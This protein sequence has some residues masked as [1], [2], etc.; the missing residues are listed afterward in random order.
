[1][2]KPKRRY[3]IDWLRVLLIF[4]VF[5]YHSAHFFV[6]WHWHVKDEVVSPGFTI[7]MEF[8]Q[9]WMLPSIFI[10]S[11]ASIWYSLGFQKPGRFV[12]GK[13]TRLLV[14]LVFG[15]F[16]LSPH[17]VYL[18][19][20]TY[21]Q[22]S[23]SFIKWF[24]RFFDGMY[25]L[26]G[27]FAWIGMH[28]WYLFFLFF[29]TLILLPLFLFLRSEKGGVVVR[30]VGSILKIPGIIYI[31]GLILTVPVAYI[32]PASILGRRDFAGWNLVYYFII[33][34]FGFLIFADERIQDSIVRQRYV[35]LVAGIALYVTFGLGITFKSSPVKLGMYHEVLR[36]W[37]FILAIFGFGMKHLKGT[38]RFLGYATEAVLPFYMLHQPVIL[39][40]GVWVVQLQ[41]PVFVK[42]VIILVLSFIGIMVLYE[43]L[44]RVK[45]LRFLFGM[46][47]RRG[48]G[49]TSK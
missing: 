19:R 47:V 32:N 34:I 10:V 42:Y 39:L 14:P 11:S 31:L 37:C 46:K 6:P 44:R 8:L 28:L 25:G 15:I 20:L 13:L 26:G 48:S 4:S 33:L 35:S 43:G 40:V 12:R 27:N 22:F 5:L 24:P 9:M 29:F 16:V 23:G 49:C 18:E 45:V 2:E 3:D 41:I 21:G 7:F 30:A 1:M 17:Q 38:N 36:S